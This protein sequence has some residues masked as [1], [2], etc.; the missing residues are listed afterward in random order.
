MIYFGFFADQ[1]KKTSE[2]NCL[3]FPMEGHRK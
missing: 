1:N 3:V 2:K